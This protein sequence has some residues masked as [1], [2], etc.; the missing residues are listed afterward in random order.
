MLLQRRGGEGAGEHVAHGIR[1]RVQ[2]AGVPAPEAGVGV[3]VR[4]EE[5]TLMLP[6]TLSDR[7][8]KLLNPPPL[9]RWCLFT[10][11]SV[12]LGANGF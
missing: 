10:S 4:I 1:T 11:L 9:F 7:W 8:Q 6:R 2:S 3:R 5:L 12:H